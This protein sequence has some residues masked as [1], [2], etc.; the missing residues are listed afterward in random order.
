MSKPDFPIL[1]VIEEP[2]PLPFD[3]RMRELERRAR[4]LEENC[5]GL[6]ADVAA[7]AELLRRKNAN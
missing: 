3:D 6:I 4:E 5:N 1:F 2:A 7:L